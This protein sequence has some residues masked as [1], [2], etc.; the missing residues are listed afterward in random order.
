M[1]LNGTISINSINNNSLVCNGKQ[2]GAFLV[3]SNQKKIHIICHSNCFII[4][5]LKE[6]CTLIKS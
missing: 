4:K 3:P 1:I 5:L 2:F 6:D